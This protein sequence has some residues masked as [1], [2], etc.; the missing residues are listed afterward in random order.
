ME[1][2]RGKTR[3]RKD[4]EER[5]WLASAKNASPLPPTAHRR[6]GRIDKRFFLTSFLSSLLRSFFFFV[7]F[8]AGEIHDVHEWC[9]EDRLNLFEAL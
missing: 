9:I 1:E 2:A 3:W 4:K 7:F 8:P 5:A 6:A